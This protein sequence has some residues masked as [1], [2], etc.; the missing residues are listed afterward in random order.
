MFHI[1]ANKLL[2]YIVLLIVLLT[3]FRFNKWPIE[4]NS[5]QLKFMNK[6]FCRMGYDGN[7]CQTEILKVDQCDCPGGSRLSS[8]WHHEKAICT[9]LCNYNPTLGIINSQKEMWEKNQ[10]KIQVPYYNAYLKDYS[11]N[12]TS[13]NGNHLSKRMHEIAEGYDFFSFLNGTNL[14]SVIEYGCGPIT[15]LHNIMN[16]NDVIVQDVTLVDPLI[17]IYPTIE[18]CTYSSGRLEGLKTTLVS[19]TTEQYGEVSNKQFDTVIAI[20]VLV[21]AK[22]ALEFLNTIHKSLKIGGLLIFQER[23][24]DDRHLS[25]ECEGWHKLN[26]IQI[27]YPLMAHFLSHYTLEPFISTKESE[28]QKLRFQQ[29]GSCQKDFT[30]W[31][32]LRKIK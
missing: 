16:Y 13:S 19:S 1:K 3:I 10:N 4:C 14:G 2:I 31:V 30:Y 21:Y 6:C 5:N 15:Q 28:G 23:I 22:N 7:N 17:N 25:V 29:Y 12:K 20:N 27:R 24:F 9:M 26:V 8:S 18:G 32:A 11:K